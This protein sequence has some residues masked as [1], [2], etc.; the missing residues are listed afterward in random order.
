MIRKG[1]RLAR[2]LLLAAV[3][4]LLG[5]SL[6]LLNASRLVGDTVPMPFGVGAAVVL[7]GS[8]EP[9]LSVGDLLIVVARDEYAVGDVVV[10]RDGNTAVTHRIVAVRDGEI[11]TRGDA[12]SA[13]DMPI[14]AD[15]IK[16]AVA[17][18]VPLVGYAVLAIRTPWGTLGL[19]VAALL[20]WE[21]SFRSDR[22]HDEKELEELRAE[23]ESLRQ[24]QGDRS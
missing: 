9:E 21:R 2:T 10:Y 13:D 4:L 23:I 11:I 17:A 16:G 20:L 3:A 12:N 18:A 24:E 14:T 1:K 15:R 7:S 22:A 6:Y 8:M 5:L 19:L